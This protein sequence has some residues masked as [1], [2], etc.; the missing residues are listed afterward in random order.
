MTK[1]SP[2][3]KTQGLLLLNIFDQ[4]PFLSLFIFSISVKL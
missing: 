2:C 3:V 4:I 1:D